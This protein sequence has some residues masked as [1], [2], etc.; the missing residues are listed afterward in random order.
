MRRLLAFLEPHRGGRFASLD[1]FRAIAA[2]GVLVYHVAGYAQL[3]D[4]T[5]VLNR[6]L[7]NLGNFGVATFFL[8]SGFLLYRPFV[9]NWFRDELPPD[10]IVYI[11][12]RFLRIFPAYLVALS[13]FLLLDLQQN[14]NPKPDFFFTLYSLTQVY[15][16]SY[17]FA[18][19]SVAWTLAIEVSFYLA[20]PFIAAGIRL[21]GRRARTLR[22]KVEAQ[23]VGLGVLYVIS[24][25]YRVVVAG[26]R[27]FEGK[28]NVE[29]LWL[30]NYF[31]WFALGMLLAVAVVWTDLGHRLPAGFQRLANTGWACWLLALASYV[32][33]M[34][35]R[36]PAGGG[37][38]G[39][40][41]ETTVDMLVR[42]FFNGM[43]A[44]FFLLPGIIARRDTMLIRR[45]LAMLVPAYLGTISYGIYLWHKLWLDYFKQGRGTAATRWSFWVMLAAVLGAS[46]LTASLSY[47]LIERPIMKFKDPKRLRRRRT[48]A[49]PQQVVAP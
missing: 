40:G 19:L 22:M 23:L 43:A 16:N 36:D 28:G 29:H 17:G 35:L 20:L 1:G 47:F 30:P 3:T 42:F 7:N 9:A 27:Q 41:R 25:I 33:L 4:G 18:G 48:A 39:A 11:R 5:G 32:V 37:V 38:G 13:V 34:M 6:F 10:P 46:I 44:F 15:R 21:I 31:D 12:H 14:K 45:W 24:L 8:L 49:P 26:P 2:I